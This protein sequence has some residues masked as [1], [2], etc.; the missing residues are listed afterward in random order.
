M[1]AETSAVLSADPSNGCHYFCQSP[2]MYDDE[3]DE[4]PKPTHTA[5][6]MR[7][8]KF[9][10]KDDCHQTDMTDHLFPRK[11]VGSVLP[12]WSA[13]PW[14]RKFSALEWTG[15]CLLRPEPIPNLQK[16]LC[17]PNWNARKPTN[18]QVASNLFQVPLENICG[19]QA[20]VQLFTTD[21]YSN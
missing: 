20:E 14:Q 21:I 5:G 19:A 18:Q 7:S 10:N 17:N 9:P 6:S 15:F 16:F 4:A 3:D 8:T 12:G 11:N 1:R 2:L 13:L